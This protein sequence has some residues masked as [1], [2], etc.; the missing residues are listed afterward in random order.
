VKRALLILCLLAPPAF[1]QQTLELSGD[2]WVATGE[3][4]EPGSDEA[5]IADARRALAENHPSRA[6]HLLTRWIDEH[7]YTDN[8]WLPEAY[9]LRGDA[10]TAAGNE[11]DAL[12][13]Y[14][15]VIRDFT[16][17][18][19]FPKAVERELD[20]GVAYLNGMRKKFL[21]LRI[22]NATSTG[23]ELL[24]RVQERMVGSE[25]AER[26]MIE[27]AD[28]YYRKRDMEMAAE[29]YDIF[30]RLYPDSR[31]YKKALQR[32]IY[33]NIA[34]FKGPRY[35]ASGLLAASLLIDDFTRRFPV[36]AER[37]GINSALAARVDESAAAQLLEI[38]RWYL[39]RD[40][41]AS[42]RY[43]LRRMIRRY[44]RTNAAAR[45]LAIFDERGWDMPPPPSPAGEVPSLRGGGGLLPPSPAE[46][47]TDEP[48]AAPQPTAPT[49]EPATP[50]AET[51][52]HKEQTP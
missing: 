27:L 19:S 15:T 32:Q 13:D 20:I 7:K 6:R 39:R 40:D 41:P 46:P 33:A 18:P 35:D 47:E 1:A 49:G 48:S 16:A 25:L 9:L 38:A 2:D 37:T 21:G 36:E 44:P 42:A 24:V 45:A 14:E 10:K 12:Y 5:I 50:P 26:A 51:D 52:D 3:A 4:P 17:S 28:Y 8:A 23:E 43:T 11:Y 30:T 31:Y 34:R 22:D 29:A